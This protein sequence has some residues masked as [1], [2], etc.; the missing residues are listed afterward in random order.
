MAQ[1]SPP[2]DMN[3]DNNNNII[4]FTLSP[5]FTASEHEYTTDAEQNFT[6]NTD[7][8]IPIDDVTNYQPSDIGVRV[9]AITGGETTEPTSNSITPYRLWTPAD[10][11]TAMWFDASDV[12]TLT[13]DGDDR[14]SQ[15]LDKSGN[16]HHLTATG[17]SRPT[18]GLRNISSLG[19]LD[20]NGSTMTMRALTYPLFDTGEIIASM[21][22]DDDG[23]T[24]AGR[25]YFH[26]SNSGSSRVFL[27]G[28]PSFNYGETYSPKT[29]TYQTGQQLITAYRDG[30]NISIGYNGVTNATGKPYAV[31]ILTEF[32]LF[33]TN[34]ASA[35]TAGG[36]GEL[37]I[38]E[39]YS[40]AVKQKIDGYLAWK[41]DGGVAGYFV[42][43]LDAGSPYKSAPPTTQ[44][45]AYVYALD[46]FDN[47][48][49]D[50]ETGACIMV[51]A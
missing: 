23:A 4:D 1:A 38:A 41:W 40:L 22:L 9:K 43:L 17:S 3:E 5:D 31:P 29:T 18:I 15:M 51:E 12:S 24:G 6:D 2:T 34:A 32:Y 33:S 14:I 19:A 10:T 39:T 48:I 36:F 26:A 35:F 46:E 11:N 8:T 30:V 50:E 27:D 16:N 37:V 21:I 13:N 7:N 28:A 45:P 49:V 44:E 25:K 47:P 42:G 20:F